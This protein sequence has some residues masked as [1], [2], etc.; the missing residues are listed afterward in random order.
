[1]LRLFQEINKGANVTWIWSVF[2]KKKWLIKKDAE[3]SFK[4]FGIAKVVCADDA[5]TG[6]KDFGIIDV[7]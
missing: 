6:L 4:G 5:Y 3:I 2:N 7:V 1:M